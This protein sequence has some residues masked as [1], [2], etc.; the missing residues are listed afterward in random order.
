MAFPRPSHTPEG[1]PLDFDGKPLDVRIFTHFEMTPKEIPIWW[2][3]YEERA[4]KGLFAFRRARRR[5]MRYR[6][7]GR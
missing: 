1:I 3:S 5:I 4:S 2:R 6:E 7:T